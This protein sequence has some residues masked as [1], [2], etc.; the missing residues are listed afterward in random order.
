VEE[1][2]NQ[3]TAKFTPASRYALVY[4]NDVLI[5]DTQERIISLTD[6]VTSLHVRVVAADEVHENVYV[7]NIKRK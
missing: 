1:G 5:D 4:V 3:V 2:K 7:V 6:D